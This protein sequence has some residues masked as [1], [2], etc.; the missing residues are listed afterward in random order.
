V[1]SVL[2]MSREVESRCADLPNDAELDQLE[3]QLRT[4]LRNEDEKEEG[5]PI[6][7]IKIKIAK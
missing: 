2:K 1:D 7:T 6:I 5:G 3:V 4:A